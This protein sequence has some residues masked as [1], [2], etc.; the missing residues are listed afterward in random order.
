MHAATRHVERWAPEAGANRVRSLRNLGF[1][2]RLVAPWLEVA[3][4][5]ASMRLFQQYRSD[6]MAERETNH[7]SWVFPRP[8]YQD[9][10]DW[11]AASRETAARIDPGQHARRA[12]ACS[13]RAAR[14]SPPAQ[15]DQVALPGAL[16]E[17]VAP[18]L[19][20]TPP[21]ATTSRCRPRSL[22]RPAPRTQST[23]RT[24]RSSRSRPCN[25]AQVMQR[26][27]APL[28]GMGDRSAGVAAMSPGLRSVLT[29]MLERSVMRRRARSRRARPRMHP[30]S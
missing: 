2:D 8:W 9:E 16:Y 13:R 22:R 28:I 7:V 26:A 17:H 25:A 5:S 3:Q 27:V 24:R 19:S 21:R 6:G 1:V 10:L 11:M 18:S 4:K 23:T 29:T 14:S 12:D 30:S 20:I 15:R